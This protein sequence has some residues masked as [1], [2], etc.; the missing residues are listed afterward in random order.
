M[1]SFAEWDAENNRY[2]LGPRIAFAQ[3]SYNDDTCMNPT[4]ELSYWAFGLATAQR[5]ME[6][7]GLP[8]VEKWD[9][10]ISHLS[11]LPVTD[12][13]YVSGETDLDSYRRSESSG[14]DDFTINRG[15]IDHPTMLAPLGML[16]GLK[17]DP[18]IMKRTLFKVLNIWK[19]EHTWGWDFP[20][21]A[22]TAARLGEG[23]IAV[24]LL[25]KD[26]DHNVYLAN[27]YNF[28]GMVYLP[29][30]GGLLAAVAMMAAG[31]DRAPQVHAPGFPRDGSWTV[32]YEGLEK[33]P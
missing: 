29:G 17:A 14:S 7:L 18:A 24:N 6:R 31:W 10:V 8:R 12:G 9:H 13:L 16:P 23:K 15:I 21:A 20:L 27:G 2:V 3:E 32:R 1:A 28:A 22:M 26:T 4:F 11:E 33:M 30:N 19:W 5:W 25:L